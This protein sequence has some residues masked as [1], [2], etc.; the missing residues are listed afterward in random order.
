[1][2][3]GM[4]KT[5]AFGVALALLLSGCDEI[6]RVEK[7]LIQQQDVSQQNIDNAKAEVAEDDVLTFAG[8]AITPFKRIAALYAVRDTS[9]EI[10]HSASEDKAKQL[11]INFALMIANNDES[12]DTENFSHGDWLVN[13]YMSPDKATGKTIAPH[14]IAIPTNE[15]VDSPSMKMNMSY[16]VEMVNFEFAKMGLGLDNDMNVPN[17]IY[18]SAVLPCSEVSIYYSPSDE[19]IYI[20]ILNATGLVGLFNSD[21]LT[22]NLMPS[23]TT[24]LDQLDH[25][26]VTAAHKWMEQE[27]SLVTAMGKD[28]SKEKYQQVEILTGPTYASK[29]FLENLPSMIGVPYE[30]Y[31]NEVL[32][33]NAIN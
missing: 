28:T 3:N 16:V 27:T 1:M 6:D 33:K 8:G 32:D 10:D 26:V 18:R 15:I 31:S 17:G 24:Q 2:L 11:A 22:S 7:M 12:K 14:V 21:L 23:L 13:G 30:H 20:D 19:V 25:E 29:S 4:M 5:A 9:G